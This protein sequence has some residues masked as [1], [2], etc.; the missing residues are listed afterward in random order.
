MIVQA[1]TGNTIASELQAR[2]FEP[3]SLHD[4]SFATLSEIDE[5]HTHGYLSSRTGPSTSQPG[6]PPAS[7]PPARS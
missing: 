4:S 7:E 6:A 3:L 1:V 5:L 2:L